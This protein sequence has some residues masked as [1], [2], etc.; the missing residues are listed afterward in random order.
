M[1]DKTHTHLLRK[2]LLTSSWLM[3]GFLELAAILKG[4]RKQLTSMYSWWTYLSSHTQMN[5][6]T[7]IFMSLL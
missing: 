7:L 4:L 5:R 2:M 3:G 1:L 6:K